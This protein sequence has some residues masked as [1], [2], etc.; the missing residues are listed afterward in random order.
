MHKTNQISPK[1]LTTSA[2]ETTIFQLESNQTGRTHVLF[3]RGAHGDCKRSMF[4]SLK[5]QPNEE[6]NQ[7]ANKTQGF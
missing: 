6:G 5:S 3:N 2:K 7:N 4:S 1:T